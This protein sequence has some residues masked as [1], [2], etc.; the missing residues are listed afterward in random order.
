MILFNSQLRRLV[1]LLI[2]GVAA[3]A[4]A[5][6]FKP[7]T[8]FRVIKTEF[9]DI[10]F[11][12]ESE[13]TARRLASFADDIYRDMSGQLGIQIPHRLPVVITPHT[14]MFNG[15]YADLPLPRIMLFDTPRSIEWWSVPDGL[16]GLFIHELAHAI[17]LSTQRGVNVWLYRIFGGWFAPSL[18][19]APYFM[20]EGVTVYMESA[21]GFGRANDPISRQILR[22][23]I[24]EGKFLTPFQAS[25][26]IDISNQRGAFYEYG[27]LF[28]KWLVEKYGME[29]YALLWQA[30]GEF[31][32]FSFN[33]Y[34]SGFYDTFRQVYG[35]YFL[36]EWEA[37]RDSLALDGIE[38]N[39]G[40]VYSRGRRVPANQNLSIAALA[41]SGSKVFILDSGENRIRVFDTDRENVRAFGTRLLTSYDIGISPNG[42]TLLISGFRMTGDRFLAV[43]NEH[44]ADTGRRT[45]RSIQGLFHARYFRDGV[46]GARSDLHNSLLVFED[47]H[48]NSEVLF[49][50]ND[51]LAFSGP[52][53]LDDQRIAFIAE[54]SGI[55]ELM[56]Y[57][58]TTGE[59]F[60]VEVAG[61]NVNSARLQN[62]WRHMRG[63]SVSEGKL[64][65]SHNADDRMFKLA[66][67]NL[68]TMQAVFSERDFS[69][70]VFQPVVTNGAIFYRA[71]FS[72]ED[73]FLRFPERA[74]SLSG[75]QTAV[76]LV[77]VNA[78]DYGRNPPP[79][80]LVRAEGLSET[81]IL[82]GADLP[83]KRYFGLRYMH[84]FQAW[85]PLPLIRTDNNFSVDGFGIISLMTEP[86][87]RNSVQT[88]VYADF[89]YRMARVDS[90]SWTNTTAGFPLTLGFSDT[91]DDAPAGYLPNRQTRVSLTGT[92][93]P[94]VGSGLFEPS[95]GVRYVRVADSNGGE[96]AYQ[97]EERGNSMS[98]FAGF[99]LSSLRRRPNEVFGRGALLSVL[100]SNIF[101]TTLRESSFE[102]RFEG[103]FRASTQTRLPLRLSL[104][105]AYD[106]GGMNLHGSSLTYG[107][108]L[109]SSVSSVEYLSQGFNL[110]WI[111]GAEAA[112]GLFS[113]E[114]QR[115]LSHAYFN[116]IFG[117]L[118]LRN[119]LYDSG[120]IAK[121]EGISLPNGGD[122]RLAQS[123]VLHL[124][125]V[126]SVLPMKPR[127]FVLEPY[128]SGAWRFSNAIMGEREVW[129]LWSIKA[130]VS[131]RM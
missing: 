86:T 22:Q 49:R 87:G 67:V 78:Q 13:P 72:A 108:P 80:T 20:V 119:V 25:N 88:I 43:V 130:G 71:K 69:G 118:A 103:L 52:Q 24:H 93:S 38:E 29:K 45:G 50:G 58:Y 10:I 48:G 54:R 90:L 40:T 122:L 104:Y 32:S 4:N 34:K 66:S 18:F 129:N 117:T 6:E 8:S 28:S 81:E 36:Q 128:V 16:K 39:P 2:F 120:N 14:D 57:N 112:F 63:L 68:D 121:P 126:T 3:F 97:W 89:K 106:A 7:F 84:P 27:G 131:F 62:V 74:D 26:L 21:S 110:N 11:P 65:F 64:F 92:F 37:F 12:R 109:F 111:A 9:F 56:V 127:P 96:S 77:A 15:Y 113:V 125:L 83:T 42:E 94:S 107:S 116:R 23:A 98:Y 105:G 60:R 47:F 53:V 100:G 55:K 123:L 30:M 82:P 59:L 61:N 1:F 114:I 95:L 5:Q 91:A 101:Y 35:V 19:T 44:R 115:N 70:G 41:S 76:R 73:G 33:M 75:I 79:D 17:S 99:T 85:L 46:I 51:L 31:G 102:P 124:G